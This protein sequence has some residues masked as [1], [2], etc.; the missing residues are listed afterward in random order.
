M[1]ILIFEYI[2]GGGMIDCVLPSSLV[3]EGDLMVNAII[4][5]FETLPTQMY[6]HYETTA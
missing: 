1:N 2:T 6:V 5:D 3:R 4:S